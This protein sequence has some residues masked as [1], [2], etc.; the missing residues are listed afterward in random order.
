MEQKEKTLL[1][2]L[3]EPSEQAKAELEGLVDK[4][5]GAIGMEYGG[6]MAYWAEFAPPNFREFLK[7]LEGSPIGKELYHTTGEIPGEEIETLRRRAKD[8]ARIDKIT[9]DWNV[10]IEAIRYQEEHPEE[11]RKANEWLNEYSKRLPPNA[12][13]F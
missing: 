7:A 5:E 12:D 6:A 10:R 4:H 11:V 2:F 8:A 3:G 1:I 13:V 9:R